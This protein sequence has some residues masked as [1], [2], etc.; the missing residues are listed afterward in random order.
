MDDVIEDV[1]EEVGERNVS[2]LNW[3]TRVG[4]TYRVSYNLI[5]L[6][7]THTK[8]Y[9]FID[10]LRQYAKGE[11][12]MYPFALSFWSINFRGLIKTKIRGI[13]IHFCRVV[14]CLLSSVT[15]ISR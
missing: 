12:K 3:I 4:S 1:N 2:Y 9:I 15:H 13:S 10:I 8:K 14:E 6:N 7:C 5:L 11:G